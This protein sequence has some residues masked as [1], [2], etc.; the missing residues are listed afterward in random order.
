MSNQIMTA[1]IGEFTVTTKPTLFHYSNWCSTRP[2]QL[3]YELGLEDI[4]AVR[5]IQDKSFITTEAY[6]REIHPF[7]R[8]PAFI[9]GEF[10]L[11][12][13]GAIFLHL[14]D[15]H[16]SRLSSEL[17]PPNLRPLLYQYL[18]FACTSL[19]DDVL[20]GAYWSEK[21][22]ERVTNYWRSAL[23]PFIESRIVDDG[24]L[25][26]STFTVLDIA[27]TYE[28]VQL[29]KFNEIDETSKLGRYLQRLKK[30]P[31]FA[32]TFA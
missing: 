25:E 6:K 22:N 20:S 26:S 4:V 10:R 23:R 1:D 21:P 31:S 18:F 2:L 24:F 17:L 8:V 30:R 12:E 15:K 28:L 29:E 13:S 16:A 32:K 3:I 11:I 14:L 9:D 19:Y 27:M 7:G 5:W